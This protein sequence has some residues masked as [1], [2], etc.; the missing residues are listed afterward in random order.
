MAAEQAVL[1]AGAIHVWLAR[2]DAFALDAL[3]ASCEHW[4]SGSEQQRY[5][6]LQLARHRQQFLL[7]RFMVRTVLSEYRPDTA[8]ADWHFTSNSYGKPAVDA[9]RHGPSPHYN[10]SHS[11]GRVALAVA[12]EPML[13][14]DIEG[15]VR[16][17]RVSRIANRYFAPLEAEALLRLHGEAQ[18]ERF[19]ELWTLKEAYIK[20]CGLGLAIPLN[21]FSFALESP[22]QIGIGFSPERDDVA[23][24]WQF[25]LL[26][27][28]PDYRLALALKGEG[29]GSTPV[30][31]SLRDFT[32]DGAQERGELRNAV[33]VRSSAAAGTRRS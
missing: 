24:A 5:R 13:G 4:L 15:S 22:G 20:A 33:I 17:R 32:G 16:P 30:Q 6:R 8:P 25:W 27:T 1:P 18:R 10:L 23:S 9:A 19:Y 2:Q 7:S 14:V 21:Q 28:D 11:N 29:G 12:A 31:V 26:E 3:Q